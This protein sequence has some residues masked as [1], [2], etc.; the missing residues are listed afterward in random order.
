MIFDNKNSKVEIVK[1]P[2]D[3]QVATRE[4]EEGDLGVIFCNIIT[5]SIN[6]E[7]GEVLRINLKPCYIG[8]NDGKL[9]KVRKPVSFFNVVTS[10]ISNEEKKFVDFDLEEKLGSSID[11]SLVKS[12]FEKADL[13]VAHNASFVR[14]WIDKHVGDNE[15]VWG[16]T[17]DHVDWSSK[18]FPSR[19]LESLAVFSGYYYDFSS[20]VDSLNSVVNCLNKNSVLGEF[21]NRALTPDLQVFAAN[22]PFELKDL[23]KERRYRWNPDFSCWWLPLEDKAHGDSESEWLIKN[24]PGTEP[25]IFEIDSKFRFSR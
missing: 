12:L 14:P 15:I 21:I 5:T 9:S 18:G 2:A 23:L 6:S 8:K 25:Q 4:Q 22:A 3:L 1:M 10:D 13:V 17:L 7:Q 20:S 16:C 19:N 24:V 11:W